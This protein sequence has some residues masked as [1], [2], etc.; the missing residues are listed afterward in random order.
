MRRTLATLVGVAAVA[1]SVRPVTAQF[2]IVGGAVLADFNYST[3][4]SSGQKSVLGFAAGITMRREIARGFDFAP[5][6][7]YILKGTADDMTSGTEKLRMAYAEIPVLFR[8]R[9]GPADAT[10]FFVTAGPTIGFK[11]SCTVHDPDGTSRDCK[12]GTFEPFKS[13]DIGAAFGAGVSTGKLEVSVRYEAGLTDINN[14]GFTGAATIKNKAFV[15]MV[16]FIL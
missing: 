5:E 10:H 11:L 16:G 1:L 9:F 14:S 12:T 15:A 8:Y 4:S 3:G 13:T 7:I 6:A 2:G